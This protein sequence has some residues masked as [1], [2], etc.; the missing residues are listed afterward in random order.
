MVVFIDLYLMSGVIFDVSCS[1]IIIVCIIILFIQKHLSSIENELQRW[2]WLKKGIVKDGKVWGNNIIVEY[3]PPKWLNPTE[4]WF[5]YDWRVWKA[6]IVCIIYKWV[7]MEL[8][9][10]ENEWWKIVVRKLTNMKQWMLEY[11]CIF[12]DI[13]FK[14]WDI[15]E[16]PNEK[17]YWELDAFKRSILKYCQKMG[18]ISTSSVFFSLRNVFN[19]LGEI[20]YIPFWRLIWL[21]IWFLVFVFWFVLAVYKTDLPALF[22][23]WWAIIC[24]IWR[25]IVYHFLISLNLTRNKSVLKFTENWKKI[26]AKIYWYKKFLESCEEDQLKKLME[27]DLLY[28]DK[29]LPY[30]IALG[31]EDTISKKIPKN[32]ISSDNSIADMLRLEKIL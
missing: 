6:D 16:L 3:Q 29:T 13:L 10:L 22:T 17:I 20:S 5:L 21:C 26:V 8:V 32:V 12:W 1:I 7:N 19:S 31:L 25:S 27:E 18:R 23:E 11:E 24:I 15:V 4:V 2:I 14:K 30:A 28:F 9:S